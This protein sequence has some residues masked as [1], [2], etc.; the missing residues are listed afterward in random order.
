[1]TRRVSLSIPLPALPYLSSADGLAIAPVSASAGES[2]VGSYRGA[3]HS[4]TANAHITRRYSCGKQ[5]TFARQ[6]GTQVACG[7]QRSRCVLWVDG[8]RF[9]F[10]YRVSRR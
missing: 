2:G 3:V 10:A 7:E 4:P 8:Y 1:M 9:A 6:Q 5:H